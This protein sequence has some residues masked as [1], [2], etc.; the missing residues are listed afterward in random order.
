MINES[1][2]NYLRAIY[3][4]STRKGA[5]RSKDLVQYLSVSKNTVSAMLSKIKDEGYLSHKNYGALS[6]TPKGLGIAMKL[7]EKH[8]L[9]EL[10]LTR[11]LKRNPKTV[12]PEACLLEH[13]FSPQSMKAMKKLLGNPKTDP[14]G[15]PIYQ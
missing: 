14:H 9:I 3:V 2:E 13:D 1:R 15:S 8:R 12:H 6:L 4:I 11:V 7:T 5:V 10:F